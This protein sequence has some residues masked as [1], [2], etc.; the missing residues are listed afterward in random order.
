[1]PYRHFNDGQEIIFEDLN[2][3]S[4]A[5]LREYNDRLLYEMVQRKT[6]AFFGDSF[7]VEFA[8]S[9]SITVRPGAGFQDDQTQAN[10]EPTKRL[11]YK[12][13]SSSVSIPTP[14]ASL[15]RID[16]VIVKATE[17]DDI[18]ATR[19]FKDAILLTISN[20]NLV[21]Q[22]DWD[23]DLQIVAGTPSATPSEPAVPA[24]YIKLA[25]L[26]VT[27]VT[28]LAGAGAVTDSRINLPLAGDVLIDSLA[29]VS[30][31]MTTGAETKLKTLLTE[32]D[33]QHLNGN[34]QRNRWPELTPAQV[35][36]FGNPAAGYQF[37]YNKDGTYFAKDSSGTE[38]PLGS[39]A[40]GGGGGLE[41][42]GPDGFE[43]PDAEEN[44]E[45][46][47][48]FEEGQSNKLVVWLKVPQGYLAGR[49]IQ[50]YHSLYSPSAADDW[51]MQTLSTLVRKNFDAVTDVTNQL[52]TNTGDIT[53]TIA[54][55]YRQVTTD[56]T[57]ASG[58]INSV[59]VQPGDLIKVELS[60][61]APAGTD[62]SADL[63]FIPAATEVTFA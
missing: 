36:A 58:E 54:S 19:K 46:V 18:S 62:D 45:F 53:N 20:Q 15:D 4:K 60:R 27:T 43:P 6:D 42:N 5:M 41:W 24:G 16:I 49:Q 51:K 3:V 31:G 39:G 40:G 11:L 28:G 22:K 26:F 8:T 50:M 63:R 57:N 61:V 35:T 56:I 17:K 21:V 30:D 38:T 55:Q 14:D 34:L 13:A 23:L 7:L 48:L 25:S 9:T 2:A 59:V 1:M 33:A 29:Y 32:M 37:M 47:Y 52:T 10:P 44:G 12:A